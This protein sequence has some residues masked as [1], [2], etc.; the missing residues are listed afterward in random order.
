MFTGIIQQLGRVLSATRLSQGLSLS[1]EHTFTDIVRGE[2]IS[3]NGVCLTVTEF[4]S[5]HLVFFL[6]LETLKITSFLNLELGQHVHLERALSM[7]DSVSGHW[8]SGHVDG[9]LRVKALHWFG[10]S[11]ELVLDDIPAHAVPWLIPKGSIALQGVSLTLN[12]VSS[13]RISLMLIPETLQKTTLAR[14]VVGSLLHV[15]YDMM[16]KTT[17]HQL[18]IFLNSYR[19]DEV[20]HET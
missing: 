11:L 6:S 15:E 19:S 14:S 1:I 20:S 5:S 10:D 2:S 16:A 17:A 18:Q 4:S 12:Q 9:Q 3:V 13:D 8:V 7:G